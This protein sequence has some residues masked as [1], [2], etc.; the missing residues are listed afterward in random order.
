MIICIILLLIISYLIVLDINEQRNNDYNSKLDDKLNTVTPSDKEID[1]EEL[2]ELINGRW[3]SC[4]DE[5][6]YLFRYNKNEN[7]S[8]LGLA[9]SDGF[10]EGS[11]D[12][13]TKINNNRFEVLIH[14]PKI[15]C[16]SFGKISDEECEMLCSEILCDEDYRTYQIDI[17]NISDKKIYIKVMDVEDYFDKFTSFTNFNDVDIPYYESGEILEN[18]KNNIT[19]LEE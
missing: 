6:C 13:I 14:H 19:Y 15:E 8:L 3:Y 9:M 5:V 1:T 17:R 4:N 11:I 16:S 10:F 2:K 12:K 18:L 7:N